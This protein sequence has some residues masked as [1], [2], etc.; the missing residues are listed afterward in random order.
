MYLIVYICLS[1]GHQV[2]L[3][4]KPYANT[5]LKIYIDIYRLCDTVLTFWLCVIS[6]A[7]FAEIY[8]CAWFHRRF[9]VEVYLSYLLLRVLRIASTE[10]VDMRN[11][12]KK[13]KKR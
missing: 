7:V 11:D 13:K 2:L 8:F 4:H 5:D 9:F 1:T 6:L 12:V 10:K 3:L